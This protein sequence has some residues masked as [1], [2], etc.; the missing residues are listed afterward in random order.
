MRSVKHGRMKS[1][2][3]INLVCSII[4]E[5]LVWGNSFSFDKEYFERPEK[6]IKH[7]QPNFLSFL[8][9]ESFLSLLISTDSVSNDKDKIL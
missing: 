6:R 1:N 4:D 3:D 9:L 7:N 8:N 5:G 2:I